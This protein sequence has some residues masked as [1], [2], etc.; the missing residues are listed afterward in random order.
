MDLWRNGVPGTFNFVGHVD[1][2]SGHGDP[3]GVSRGI[4]KP[5][6]NGACRRVHIDHPQTALG[7][8]SVVIHYGKGQ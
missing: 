7:G 5:H 1:V 3:Q 8:G 2:P 6:L 4:V